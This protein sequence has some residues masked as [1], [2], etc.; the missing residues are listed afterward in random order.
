MLLLLDLGTHTNLTHCL[1]HGWFQEWIRAWFHNQTEINWGPY[2]RFTEMLNKPPS[3]IISSKPKL[4]IFKRCIDDV[5]LSVDLTVHGLS[6]VYLYVA[7][8]WAQWW[9]LKV[10]LLEECPHHQTTV[11][12]LHTQ[13]TKVK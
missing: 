5:R 6:A 4:K 13:T 9:V 1:V 10:W 7:A 12:N 8:I 3:L 2:G 11:L